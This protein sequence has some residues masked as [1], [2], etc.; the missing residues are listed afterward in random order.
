M[1]TVKVDGWVGEILRDPI[2]KSPLKIEPDW[3]VSDYG[4]RYPILDGVYDLRALTYFPGSVGAEW[5]SGQEAYEK[6]SDNLAQHSKEDYAAQR[7]GV[8]DV[9][10]EIPISG[11]CLDVGGNDGRLRA[12][13]SPG[14][15][16]LSMDPFI[17]IVKEPR[18]VECKRV[19]PFIDE[20]LNFIAG[21]AEHL[22]FAS[23]CF[24]TVHLR[25]VLDHFLNP[26]LALREAYRVLRTDG[27]L[28]VG[29][30]VEGGRTGTDDSKT[31]IKEGLRSVLVGAGFSQFKDHHIWHPTYEELCKL[32]SESGF[33]VDKAHWQEGSR[34]RVCYI[35]A[36]KPSA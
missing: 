22:P 29:L 21:L 13:L 11:R 8:E 15:E 23:E 27:A 4:R 28:I 20:P 30:Q 5:K 18:S 26:E 16:Y 35:R 7:Q 34:E 19:Y 9:Y 25:S 33:R 1:I 2:S 31:R 36:I 24:D 6:W 10:R 12:F 3:L 17:N 14:Q 32:I